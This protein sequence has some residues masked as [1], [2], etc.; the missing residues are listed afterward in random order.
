[1]STGDI[2][3][4]DTSPLCHFARE[5]WLG[6]LKA[7]VGERTAVI[8]DT[9]AHELRTGAMRDSRVQ[10]VL[11]ASWIEMRELRTDEEIA[12]LAEFSGLLVRGERNWGEA[13]VL[14]LA[15]TLGAVAVVDDGAGCKAARN[16]GVT[17]RR[18]LALLFEAVRG[19]LLTF[20]LVKALVNDL[21]IGQYR[22]PCKADDLEQ[23]AKDNGLLP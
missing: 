14:A 16:H 6:V 18:T 15:S 23:W 10:A 7:V 17:V 2:L 20:A 21:V 13:G 11:D 4:F 22:L 9:V 5:N 1:M 8:P 12:A 19:E 3:V